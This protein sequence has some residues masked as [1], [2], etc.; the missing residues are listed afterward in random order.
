M[1]FAH[2]D[3]IARCLESSIFP[4]SENNIISPLQEFCTFIMW[5]IKLKFHVMLFRQKS[6]RAFLLG[7]WLFVFRQTWA[8]PARGW[9]GVIFFHFVGVRKT[10]KAQL[11]TARFRRGMNTNFWGC[12][13]QWGHKFH[14]GPKQEH[15]RSHLMAQKWVGTQ[16]D[17][18]ICPWKHV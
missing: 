5:H 16:T 3:Q 14:R 15:Q 2:T 1:T 7:N 4:R 13:K 11:I 9:L 18:C 10:I 6:D 17:G 8:I 12:L